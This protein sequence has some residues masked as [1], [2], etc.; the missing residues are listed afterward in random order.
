MET[1]INK[2]PALVCLCLEVWGPTVSWAMPR[3]WAFPRKC[4][5][6]KDPLYFPLPAS[7][8]WAFRKPTSHCLAALVINLGSE[9]PQ[10]PEGGLEP[11]LLVV[12]PSALLLSEE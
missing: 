9:F 5:T 10:E 1:G 3:D 6:E 11:Q 2:A 8:F 12:L 7:K 4:D